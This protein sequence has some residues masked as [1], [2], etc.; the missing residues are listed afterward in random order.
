MI[1][2][3]LV[4]ILASVGLIKGFFVAF[5][6]IFNRGNSSQGSFF[7]G[8][9]L[10]GLSIRIL[11]S[12]LNYHIA[13]DA[14]L[15]SVGLSGIL[16][17]GPFLLF[18][19]RSILFKT[20]LAKKQYLHLLPFA[21]FLTFI[22]FASEFFH[23]YINYWVTVIHLGSYLLLV[24]IILQKERGKI[25]T[26]VMNWA[27]KIVV[28]MGIVWL[29]YLLNLINLNIHYLSGPIYYSFVTYWFTLLFLDRKNPIT[30]YDSSRLSPSEP[31]RLYNKLI[32]LFEEK[33]IYLRSELSLEFVAAQMEL[34]QRILSQV[35]T[36]NGSKNFKS[37]VNH[38]RIEKAK[39]L[40]N[41]YQHMNEKIATIAYESGYNNVTSFTWLSKR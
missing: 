31:T 1:S 25:S 22:P 11:K 4:S 18:Y 14:S 27:T 5:Y 41:S 3:L 13:L 36:E 29:F 8:V 30:K 26:S 28:G 9:A 37:F 12:V 35:I 34:P 38:Y 40:L 17:T 7:L 20:P 6:L 39:S 21:L 2:N 15:S 16:L 23:R 33:E 19:I 32:A 10:L 24:C